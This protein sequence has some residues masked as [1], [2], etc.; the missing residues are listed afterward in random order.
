[1]MPTGEG[2]DERSTIVKEK[3]SEPWSESRL[4]EK[5]GAGEGVDEGK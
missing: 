2:E 1:M 3:Q 4:K 5:R